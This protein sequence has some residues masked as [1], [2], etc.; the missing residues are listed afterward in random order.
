MFGMA[1]CKAAAVRRAGAT[2]AGA[3]GEWIGCHLVLTDPIMVCPPDRIWSHREIVKLHYCGDFIRL[4]SFCELWV[5]P[6]GGLCAR[7]YF[8]PNPQP[9]FRP[10]AI[11]VDEPDGEENYAAL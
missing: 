8:R 7:F 9:H 11:L 4:N 6:L 2:R 10:T 3:A 1:P 5:A